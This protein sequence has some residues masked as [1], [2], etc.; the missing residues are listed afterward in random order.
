MRK[1][2]FSAFLV[3]AAIFALFLSACQTMTPNSSADE[4]TIQ[5]T[6]SIPPQA[7]FVQRIG[8]DLVSVNIMVGPGEEAHTYEP[9]PDQMKNLTE[10]Q[11]FFIIGVEYEDTWLPRFEEINPDLWIVDSAAGITR[12]EMT[13][14]DEHDTEDDE[15]DHEHTTG[16]DPHLWLSPAN[17]KVIA[18]NVLATLSELDPTHAE[19]FEANTAVLLADIDRLDTD[20]REALSGINQKTFM[21]FHPAWGYFAHEYDLEQISVQ[22][23]G[24]DPSVSEVAELIRTAR[25]YNIQVIFVQPSFSTEDAQAIAQEIDGE[26]AI[27][28]P[29]AEDWLSNLHAAAEAFAAALTP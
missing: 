21:V 9:T 25:S 2:A 10:S 12:I 5:V 3:S 26:I 22:V 8:G 4:G 13:S 14:S 20:I 15:E 28:D 16:L 7:Y 27:V 6:V 23:E 1:S 18:A 19:I 17:G 24:Q 29:L 11:A